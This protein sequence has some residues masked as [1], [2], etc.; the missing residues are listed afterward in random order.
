MY[1]IIV[2]VTT[3]AVNDPRWETAFIWLK[4]IDKSGWKLDLVFP[5]LDDTD[6]I[7]TTNK[8]LRVKGIYEGQS[9]S[10]IKW[11]ISSGNLE[12][13]AV[14]PLDQLSIALDASK[15]EQGMNY[16]LNLTVDNEIT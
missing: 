9:Y 12:D 11:M 1:K 3:T 14:T 8:Q 5:G 2:N 4:V 16:T 10:S 6:Y 7:S 15:L 13:L